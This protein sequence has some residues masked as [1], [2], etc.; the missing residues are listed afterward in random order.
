MI[1]LLMWLLSGID[2]FLD[3]GLSARLSVWGV[4]GDAA[5]NYFWLVAV[6]VI[7][8]MTRSHASFLPLAIGTG[9]VS[10]VLSIVWVPTTYFWQILSPTTYAKF[11]TPAWW[12]LFS[13]E[14]AAFFRIISWYCPFQL[15]RRIA[16]S[17]VYAGIVLLSIWYLPPQPMF[18]EPHSG[19]EDPSLNVEQ[20]YYS[21][22]NLMKQALFEVANEL[23]GNVDVFSIG[24]G[25]YG[26]QDVFKR[27]IEGGLAAIA[28]RF[29]SKDKTVALINNPATTLNIPLA[30]GH[31]LE[32]AIREISSKMNLDE[33]ILLLLL[34]S[35]GS[36]DGSIAVELEDLNLSD[37]DALTL[38]QMLDDAFIYWRVII[39]SACY[40][41]SFIEQL[42]SPT[43]LIMTA[44]SADRASFGCEHSR[45]WTYFGE[46]LFIEA[47]S[48]NPTLL[49]AFNAAKTI[50]AER[51]SAEGKEAS[52]P[53]IWIG[54]AMKAYL[55][56]H[57]L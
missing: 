8:L 42:K 45:D 13:V 33:D 35:H 49:A 25:A 37:L 30:S 50:V 24:F 43:T 26:G 41:G 55:T 28:S 22:D 51:E 2:D 48:E 20:T 12:C 11:L 53:Q 3:S 29:G 38:R 21:Q 54:E 46:A 18:Y 15:D 34:S 1:C 6:T 47:L 57:A 5:L 14:C 52:N 9:A 36:E 17:L 19:R 27:E 32:R 56:L 44:A 40:S 39:I 4:I 10:L 16:L 7:C 31:N 23:E